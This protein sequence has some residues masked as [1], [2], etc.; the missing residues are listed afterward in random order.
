MASTSIN[1]RIVLFLI[2]TVAKLSKSDDLILAR[3]DIVH[4]VSGLILQYKSH[5]RPANKI[6]TL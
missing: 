2:I 5:Y 6:I 4:P 1:L 3:Q